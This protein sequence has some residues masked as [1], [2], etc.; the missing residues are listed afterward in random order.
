MNRRKFLGSA[1]GGTVAAAF[2][3]FGRALAQPARP[4][5]FA[6]WGG[7]LTEMQKAIFMDPASTALGQPIETVSP[8]SYAK[9]KA[10]V[11][12]GAVEWDLTDIGGHFAVNGGREGLLEK[13]DFSV[14]DVSRLDKHWYSDYGVYAHCGA[15]V[16]AWNTDMIGQEGPKSWKDFWDVKNLPGKRSLY[17]RMWMN[18]EAALLADG[19]APEEIYPAT[20]EKVKL[21]FAKL[22]E[23]KPHIPVW[24]T[25][26]TAA[27]PP[28][29]VSSGELAL[30]TSWSGRVIEMQKEKAPIAYTLDQ[31]LAVG[32]VLA[33][34]KG[35]PYRDH[36]MKVINY[37]ISEEVQLRL[38]DYG[39]YGPVL[40]S[41]SDK[42]DADT[43]KIL[44]TAS[45]NASKVFYPSD[46]ES[47]KYMEK[48]EEEWNNFMLK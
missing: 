13:L 14:I 44:V 10:M 18:Y 11:E 47:A 22:T 20:D 29:L 48:Y 23:L 2:L 5:V 35:S 12:A 9:I 41:A 45:E 4:M 43:R 19:V 38:L 7:A 34:P 37:V 24:W 16:M 46:T 15:M 25:P 8:L 6:S 39:I 40:S 1:L 42:A 32:D 30:A 26:S 36:A 27:Q 3:P 31:A 28:Q 33:I 17:N 21:M